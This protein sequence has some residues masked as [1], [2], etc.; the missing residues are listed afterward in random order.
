V[1]PA[2][3]SQLR[4]FPA[5]HGEDVSPT[6]DVVFMDTEEKEELNMA[7]RAIKEAAEKPAA[8]IK[9]RVVGN[10]RVTHGGRAYIRDEVLEIPDDAEHKAWLQAGFVEKVSK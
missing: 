10:H 7:A 3:S 2:L 6:I 9:V 8:S 4:G 5:E 1:I